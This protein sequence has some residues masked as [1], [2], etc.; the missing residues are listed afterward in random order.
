M[1]CIIAGHRVLICQEIATL[2]FMVGIVKMD[3]IFLFVAFTPLIGLL[4]EHTMLIL[5]FVLIH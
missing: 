5:N 4:Q 2:L 3:G 1:C